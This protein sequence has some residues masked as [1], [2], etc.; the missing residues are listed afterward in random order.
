MI[1][2]WDQFWHENMHS[3]F[4]SQN[5]IFLKPRIYLQSLGNRFGK[6]SRL[7]MWCTFFRQNHKKSRFL[8]HAVAA[9]G[10]SLS[11]HSYFQMIALG[12][13]CFISGMLSFVFVND[14]IL[15]LVCYCSYLRT[16]ALLF[17]HTNQMVR[18]H[19]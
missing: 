18:G 14:F 10:C 16:I 1:G 5:F 19:V 13:I 15:F 3:Y 17:I 9:F 12:I 11:Y 7:R 6:K 2:F 8:S 4:F